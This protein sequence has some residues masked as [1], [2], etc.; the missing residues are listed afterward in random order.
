[1]EKEIAWDELTD[2]QKK[3]IIESHAAVLKTT[4]KSTLLRIFDLAKPVMIIGEKDNAPYC[5]VHNKE[6]VILI[7]LLIRQYL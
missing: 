3:V 2:A 4:E 7:N 6:S 5:R 1:M